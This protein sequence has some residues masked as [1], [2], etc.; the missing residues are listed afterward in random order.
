MS[1]RGP[2]ALCAGIL[3]SFL[4]IGAVHPHLARGLMAFGDLHFGGSGAYDLSRADL[5]YR[6]ALVADRET[7]HAHHQRAR[8]AFLHG[9]FDNALE[10]IEHQVAE[11]GT[12][13]MSSYYI[14][15]LIHGYRKEFPDAERDFK[16]F[17]KWDP[18]NWAALND[19]AWVYFAQGE[20]LEAAETSAAGLQI[21]PRNLWLL[22]MHAMSLF[23][24]GE[25][26]ESERLLMQAREESLTLTEGDWLR[27]YPGND[28][29]FAPQG[30]ASLRKAIEE[31]FTLAQGVN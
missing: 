9:D 4:L 27:A 6:M 10:L 31:N 18:E 5:Y 25:R 2:T 12:S 29:A 1:L 22:T 28:P 26:E 21:A 19:L 7:L 17:L 8:I 30:L 14:R 24:L 23:N 3:A 15:G 11:H 20:F 16:T 13:F